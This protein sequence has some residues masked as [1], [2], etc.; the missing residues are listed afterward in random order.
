MDEIQQELMGLHCID[1]YRSPDLTSSS[2][3]P[4][5]VHGTA[6]CIFWDTHKASHWGCTA[7]LGEPHWRPAPSACL[8]CVPLRSPLIRDSSSLIHNHII[9]CIQ[10]SLWA[11]WGVQTSFICHL[12]VH[13]ISSLPEGI[14]TTLLN[15]ITLLFSFLDMAMPL[16][17]MRAPA[18]NWLMNNLVSG[19]FPTLGGQ[20]AFLWPF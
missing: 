7:S 12:A 5:T 8:P 6:R 18:S 13:T 2:R 9:F 10:A 15:K 14:L 20:S 16:C 17:W 11:L 4:D 3:T 1:I 19:E